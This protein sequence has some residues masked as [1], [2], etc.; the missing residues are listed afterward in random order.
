[1][2]RFLLAIA[3]LLV[4]GMAHAQA[5]Y[6]IQPGD[7]LDISV[8]EDP[9]LNRQALVRPDGGISMLI[10]GN[11]QAG[12]RTIP[13]LE[14]SIKDRLSS[15]FAVSPTVSVSLAA[16]A[17]KE[18][19]EEELDLIKVYFLGEIASPGLKQIENG[20]TL[21]QAISIA[22][23]LGTF[24]AEKRIQVRR[25]MA[26]GKEQVYTFNYAAVQRGDTVLSDFRVAEGDVILVPER[27]LFE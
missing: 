8:L 7:V 10:A 27:R 9:N 26:S 23:G 13:Q 11:L 22:G 5:G 1:M 18:F 2:A 19:E 25:R 21:L 16:L 20:T 12:G 15:T 14:A 6:R 3:A 17:T 24:A 4:A